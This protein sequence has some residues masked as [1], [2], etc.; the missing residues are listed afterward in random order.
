MRAHYWLKNLIAA[1]EA[2]EESWG[3]KQFWLDVEVT[4]GDFCILRYCLFVHIS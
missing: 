3:G 2:Y 1:A 4:V